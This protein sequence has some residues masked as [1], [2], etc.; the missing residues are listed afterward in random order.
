MLFGAG[1]ITMTVKPGVVGAFRDF[2]FPPC[3]A[4]FTLRSEQE[5]ADAG[6][7]NLVG[8]EQKYTTK[9]ATEKFL[10]DL[11]IEDVDFMT[12]QMALGELSAKSEDVRLDEYLEL[13]PLTSTTVSDDRITIDTELFQGVYNRTDHQIM[14]KVDD[15]EGLAPNKFYFDSIGNNLIFNPSDV[16]KTISIKLPVIK[17]DI[18]CIGGESQRAEFYNIGFQG[19]FFT[20]AGEGPYFIN[21]PE[22]RKISGPSTDFIGNAA[23]YNLTYQAVSGEN[24]DY[25]RKPFRIYS[26]KSGIPLS[27]FNILLETGDNLLLESGGLLLTEES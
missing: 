9:I 4:L 7:K 10:V 26:P 25:E 21:I 15:L 11:S 13:C 20:T 18:A 6:Y 5:V 16:G 23:T 8:V 27:V 24:E 17:N 1:V 12:M 22:L 2:Y 19:S 14:I 3:Y